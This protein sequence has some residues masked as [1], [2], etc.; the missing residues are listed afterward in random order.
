MAS[1]YAA[2]LNYEAA[3]HCTIT[4]THHFTSLS[5]IKV[6]GFSVSWADSGASFLSLLFF[7]I[8]LRIFVLDER[9][10]ERERE[11]RVNQK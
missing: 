7:S 8:P 11:K 5:A 4:N 10:K 3:M 1:H 6:S 2:E 9:R